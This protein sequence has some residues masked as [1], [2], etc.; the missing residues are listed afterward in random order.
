[1]HIL[2]R[3]SY[4]R[5]D[6]QRSA[7]HVTFV[8][9][10]RQLKTNIERCNCLALPST[11]TFINTSNTLRFHDCGKRFLAEGQRFKHCNTALQLKIKQTDAMTNVCEAQQASELK[12]KAAG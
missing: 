11:A 12:R 4:L 2:M 6:S 8:C 1:M 5:F 10:R 3:A 7:L 9:R